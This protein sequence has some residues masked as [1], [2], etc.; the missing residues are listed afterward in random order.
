MHVCIQE[1][2]EHLPFNTDRFS[3]LV[4]SMTVDWNSYAVLGSTILC[5]LFRLEKK[6][7]TYNPMTGCL[8]QEVVHCTSMSRGSS[9]LSQLGKAQEWQLPVKVPDWR[10]CR[11]RHKKRLC[12]KPKRSKEDMYPPDHFVFFQSMIDDTL[13]VGGDT[14]TV[15]TSTPLPA[16]LLPSP[17][18]TSLQSLV[19]LS[20][21]YCVPEKLLISDIFSHVCALMGAYNIMFHSC[22]FHSHMS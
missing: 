2:P 19:F 16:C 10:W 11:D 6:D 21:E 9:L 3:F 4:V 7:M 5:C 17:E 13:M 8:S 18:G 1:G 20:R 12:L 14:I 15:L 22:F